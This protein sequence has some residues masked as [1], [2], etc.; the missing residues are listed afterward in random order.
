[1]VVVVIMTT[2]GRN[3]TYICNWLHG[4]ESFLR[5]WQ[6]LSWSRFLTFYGARRFITVFTRAR[7]WSLS[8][9]RCIQSTVSHLFPYSSTRRSSKWSVP[10]RF[11]NQNTFCVYDIFHACY[12]SISSSF[13]WSPKI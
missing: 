10:F 7:H 4:A 2:K 6:S 5:S 11:S 9:A 13:I 8:S 12:I 3:L 1:M